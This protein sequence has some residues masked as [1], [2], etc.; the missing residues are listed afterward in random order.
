MND[1]GDSCESG[2]RRESWTLGRAGLSLPPS[3]SAFFGG[4]RQLGFRRIGFRGR[5]KFGLMVLEKPGAVLDQLYE[6]DELHFGALTRYQICDQN[7]VA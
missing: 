4:D 7:D 2:I 3:P 1:I 6:F 5:V